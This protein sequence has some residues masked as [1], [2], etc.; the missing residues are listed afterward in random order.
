MVCATSERSFESRGAGEHARAVL[1]HRRTLSEAEDHASEAEEHDTAV[2][3]LTARKKSVRL[4]IG[5]RFATGRR[6]VAWTY[7][8]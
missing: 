4:C 1:R 6:S 3:V 8:T 5:G 7:S 2:P